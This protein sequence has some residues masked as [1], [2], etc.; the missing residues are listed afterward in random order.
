MVQKEDCL[1]VVDGAMSQKLI[2]V[3]LTLQSTEVD[4]QKDSICHSTGLK[5]HHF[6]YYFVRSGSRS[7]DVEFFEISTV[8]VCFYFFNHMAL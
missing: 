8:G 2:Y 7:K 3:E 5:V 1:A 6:S 4:S